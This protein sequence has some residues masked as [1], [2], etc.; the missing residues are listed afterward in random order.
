MNKMIGFFA[1]KCTGFTPSRTPAC[2]GALMGAVGAAL[3]AAAID[4]LMKYAGKIFVN[5]RST[6][7]P[8]IVEMRNPRVI[9]RSGSKVKRITSAINARSSS[10]VEGGRQRRI[11]SRRVFFLGIRP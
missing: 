9:Q 7:G 1:S 4:M 10:Q 5:P 8:Q 2:G 3:A 6:Q 11:G